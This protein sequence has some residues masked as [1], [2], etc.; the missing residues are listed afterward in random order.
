MRVQ[1]AD[2]LKSEYWKLGLDVDSNEETYY[3][4]HHDI[5]SP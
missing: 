2:R 3:S 1:E 5:W 4:P